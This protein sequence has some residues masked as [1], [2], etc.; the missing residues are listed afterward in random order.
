MTTPNLL[1]QAN[2]QA[3]VS[4]EPQGLDAGLDLLP[5]LPA[6]A[7]AAV[8]EPTPA[9]VEAAA[10]AATPPPPPQ[11]DVLSQREQELARRE[12]DFAQQQRLQRVQQSVMTYYEDRLAGYARA[13]EQQGLDAEQAR[14]LAGEMAKRDAQL[15]WQQYQGKMA[16]ERLIAKEEGVP[17]DALA[18]LWDE[19]AMRQ[20]AARYK[21]S[22][23]PQNEELAAVK[24]QLAELKQLLQKSGTPAQEFNQPSNR[25]GVRVTA[26]NI[27][28]LYNQWE[29]AHPNQA[30]N[31][32]E[33]RYRTV[34]FGER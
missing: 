3:P 25:G 24:R 22:G 26:D 6:D 17:V 13:Y 20:E 33:A 32:Y 9:P 16:L 14:T 34:V 7:A 8:L 4:S 15:G 12:Q 28:Q 31:P 29:V 2:G 27:D 18:N 10:P 23:G 30:G 21:R 11:P 5:E 19:T 1:T